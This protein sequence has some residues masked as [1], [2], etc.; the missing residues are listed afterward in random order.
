MH[1]LP[2]RQWEYKNNLIFPLGCRFTQFSGPRGRI[3]KMP[4]VA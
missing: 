3:T 2:L 4:V 1:I